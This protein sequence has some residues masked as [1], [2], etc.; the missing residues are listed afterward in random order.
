MKPKTGIMKFIVSIMVLVG[1]TVFATSAGAKDAEAP[2]SV[3]VVNYPLQ[4]FAER[5]DGPDVRVVFPA[6]ADGDPAFW[7]PS[8]EQ[9]PPIRRP[10]LSSSIAH[11]TPNGL[12][13]C[14]CPHPGWWTHPP[15]LRINSS[16]IAEHFCCN[17]ALE[18]VSR[19]KI[20]MRQEAAVL[21]KAL[22]TH[23]SI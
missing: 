6:P 8:P 23:S 12:P 1:V 14:R 19:M 3:Y 5:I 17:A 9:L 4:Y 16:G 18:D 10:T 13:I 2:V 11:P 20:S 21:L 7:K 22:R 15:H